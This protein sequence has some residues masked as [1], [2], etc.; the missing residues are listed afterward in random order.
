MTASTPP[1]A[2]DPVPPPMRRRWILPVLVITVTLLA[3]AIAALLLFM[4]ASRQGA[5]GSVGGPFALTAHDGSTFTHEALKGAPFTVFFGFTHCPDICPAALTEMSAV[6]EA[7][8]QRGERLRALFVTIDPERDTREV[9]ADYISNFDKRIV[10]LT[11][12]REQIDAMARQYRAYHRKVPLKD[13]DYTM[14]HTAAVY[15][16]DRNGRFVKTLDLK[17]P[18]EVV[19]RE[20]LSLL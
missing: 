9:L 12:T 14:D 11:G 17:R 18:P 13:N 6:L 19:A 5:G 8:G 7:A 1:S 2:R 16:M 20:W 3:L 10:A 15:L 4:P